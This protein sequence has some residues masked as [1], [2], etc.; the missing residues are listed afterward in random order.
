MI[1]AACRA[2]SPFGFPEPSMCSL[3]SEVC[4]NH[5]DQL[6]ALSKA[7]LWACACSTAP[8]QKRKIRVRGCL[9]LGATVGAPL[10]IT[11]LFVFPECSPQPQSQL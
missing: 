4:P 9:L 3:L 11:L 10:I 8:P 5:P 1:R 2:S 6:R 7:W